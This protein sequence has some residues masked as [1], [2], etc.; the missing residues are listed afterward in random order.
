MGNR[1]AFQ[2]VY[3]LTSAQLFGVILRIQPDRAVAED[4]LQEVFVKVWQ[5]AGSF[6]A[7]RGQVRTWLASLARNQAIDSLRRSQAQPPRVTGSRPPGS[8]DADEEDPMDQMPSPAPGPAAL[9]EQ[10]VEGRAVRACMK[11]LNGEQQQ[12]LAL[13]FYDGLSHGE[14]ATHLG[15]PLGTIKSWARRGLQSLRHCLERLGLGNEAAC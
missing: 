10:A 8:A 7:Q 15:H 4:L 5:S 1:Q 6:D 9:L 12:A 3:E 11:H 2:Q 14:V 13:A